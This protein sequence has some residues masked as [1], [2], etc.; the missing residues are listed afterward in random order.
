MNSNVDV[1]SEVIKRNA[2]ENFLS[3]FKTPTKMDSSI[4]RSIVLK[5]AS[6]S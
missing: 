1:A 2:K 5:A 4:R 3:L 6:V